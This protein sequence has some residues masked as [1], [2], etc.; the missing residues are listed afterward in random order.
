VADHW[1]G[2]PAYDAKYDEESFHS[3]GSWFARHGQYH[4]SVCYD[5]SSKQWI[6]ILY[7]TANVVATTLSVISHAIR[8][9]SFGSD[10][11]TAALFITKSSR[12]K[13]ITLPTD[14]YIIAV[15]GSAGAAEAHPS[16]ETTIQRMSSLLF[17]LPPLY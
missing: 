3:F 15:S 4:G 11:L 13:Q 17:I 10:S 6:I 1:Q 5:P 2:K 12:H 9:R 16:T 14:A 8:L 7:D